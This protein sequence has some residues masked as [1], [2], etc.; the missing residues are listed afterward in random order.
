M[1]RTTDIDPNRWKL[2]QRPFRTL[3]D[4]YKYFYPDEF[5]LRIGLKYCEA[6]IDSKLARDLIM[7]LSERHMKNEMNTEKQTSFA[8]GS[9]SMN[10]ASWEY[11]ELFSTNDEGLNNMQFQS[12]AELDESDTLFDA[13]AE[14]SEFSDS[15]DTL[16]ADQREPIEGDLGGEQ[17]LGVQTVES[18]D[19]KIEP[20]TPAPFSFKI[21]QQAI[22]IGLAAGDVSACKDI[23]DILKGVEHLFPKDIQSEI[24]TFSLKGLAMISR[25]PDILTDTFDHMRRH[26]MKLS[27][28]TYG[29]MIHGLAVAK[30]PDEAI[31]LLEGMESDSFGDG[32]K[33]GLSCYNA[34]MISHINEKS[35]RE[36]IDVYDRMIKENV[37]PNSATTQGLLIAAYRIGGR[38]RV[39][40]MVGDLLANDVVISQE[41][42]QLAM[43][44]MVPDVIKGTE[45]KITEIQNH[46]RDLGTKNELLKSASFNLL[47]SIRQAEI[48][49][50]RKPSKQ[51]PLDNILRR[52]EEAWEGALK[53]V[54]ELAQTQN[55]LK[56]GTG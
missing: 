16:D 29:A 33:P 25:N 36:V 27:E 38:E 35:W 5:L 18:T 26:E 30:R 48:E 43:K 39:Q 42:C 31:E 6:T 49:Q 40:E 47:R 4:Q 46:L 28:E 23:L 1:S 19:K 55:K 45:S 7:R 8:D 53:D 20:Y 32:I 37:K 56:S 17:T 22:K 13:K 34:I 2:L 24:W 52:R 21:F 9:F 41:N 11:P 51:V 44:I 15:F 3:F 50:N 54:L 12:S 14:F 10:D